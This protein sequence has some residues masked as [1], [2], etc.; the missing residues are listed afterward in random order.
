MDP[1]PPPLAFFLLLVSGLAASI[2]GD[3]Q[4][5]CAGHSADCASRALRNE[6]AGPR[7]P[8][9]RDSCRRHNLDALPR[10]V[11]NTPSAT[12]WRGSVAVFLG[13]SPRTVAHC[14]G[15]D[16]GHFLA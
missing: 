9:V 5:R 7:V 2:V 16:A 11:T 14:F 4:A 1:L 13:R 12:F 3:R 8:L 15:Q 6:H 10:T